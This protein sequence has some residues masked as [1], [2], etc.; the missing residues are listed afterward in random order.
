M[1]IC[2]FELAKKG[3]LYKAPFLLTSVSN[4][5]S[6]FT[7]FIGQCGFRIQLVPVELT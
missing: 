6:V 5:S 1:V 3:A 2:N 7:Q 4:Q